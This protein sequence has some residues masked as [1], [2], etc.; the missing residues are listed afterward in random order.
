MTF[1]LRV[2]LVGRSQQSEATPF[3]G[4]SKHQM[5]GFGTLAEESASA[6]KC[7]EDMTSFF[8]IPRNISYGDEF[9]TPKTFNSSRLRLRLASGPYTFSPH[10]HFPL[11]FIQ[12]GLCC[13]HRWPKVLLCLAVRRRE[14]IIDPSLG[15]VVVPP[16][17]DLRNDSTQVA[18]CIAYFIPKLGASSRQGGGIG[19]SPC[20]QFQRVARGAPSAFAELAVIHCCVRTPMLT[21]CHIRST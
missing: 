2:K 16:C 10:C 17:P 9:G 15:A 7:S 12:S 20:W 19:S 4:R 18:T 5:L 21:I 6:G 13:D 11:L 1:P 3:F 14:D 8:A